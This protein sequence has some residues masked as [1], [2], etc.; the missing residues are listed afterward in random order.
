MTLISNQDS[1]DEGFIRSAVEV[2]AHP[3]QRSA[4]IA[5]SEHRTVHRL[6]DESPD[7]TLFTQPMAEFYF[8]VPRR[9]FEALKRLHGNPFA[10]SISRP[11]VASKNVLLSWYAKVIKAGQNITDG[12]SGRLG[13]ASDGTPFIVMRDSSKNI[14][15]I[16]S[17]SGITVLDL[18]AIED[19]FRQGAVIMAMHIDQALGLP[20]V[21]AEEKHLWR[22]AYRRVLERAYRLAMAMLDRQELEDETSVSGRNSR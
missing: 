14:N 21:S 13:R 10:D 19:A 12:F 4:V 8:Q 2:I 18:D 9:K 15:K 3:G 22:Q 20:W 1:L 6:L 7:G 5:R 11:K 16:I 17:H